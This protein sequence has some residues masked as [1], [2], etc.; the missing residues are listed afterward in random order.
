MKKT[1]SIFIL[2]VACSLVSQA[3]TVN[4]M[5]RWTDSK[6]VVHYTEYAPEETREQILNFDP[7]KPRPEDPSES[8]RQVNIMQPTAAVLVEIPEKKTFNPETRQFEGKQ[9][10]KIVEARDTSNLNYCEIVQINLATFE[11]L[12]NGDL[13]QINFVAINGTQT[14]IPNKDI[15]DQRKATIDNLEKYC[16]Q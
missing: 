4:K 6:G 12:S 15:Q 1:L 9:S 3:Q 14:P 5:Y 8:V 2:F 10:Q 7:D 11:S 13:D 16:L